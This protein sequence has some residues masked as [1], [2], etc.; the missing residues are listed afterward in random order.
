MRVVGLM[1]FREQLVL[2]FR[3]KIPAL[4]TDSKLTHIIAHLMSSI[5]DGCI[6]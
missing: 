6:A 3:K 5:D 1:A 2:L 4:T